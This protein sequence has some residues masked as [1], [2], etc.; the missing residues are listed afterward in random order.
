MRKT[1]CLL[2]ALPLLAPAQAPEPIFPMVSPT[3][4]QLAW[5]E[6]STWRIWIAHA[7]GSGARVFGPAWP[8]GIGQIAWTRR[9]MIVDSNYT[10]FRLSTAGKRTKLAVVGDQFFSVGATRAAVGSGQ[11]S[12]PVTV[13][14][15]LTRKVTRIGSPTVANGE[16]SLAPDGRRLAWGGP[17]GI[18]VGPSSGGPAQLLIR[19]GACPSW[20]PNGRSIAYLERGDLHVVASGGGPGRKLVARAGGC[21]TFA[22]SPDSK[23]I[24]FT[25][26]RIDTVSIATARVTKSPPLGR[27]AGGLVWGRDGS[28]LYVTTRPVADEQALNNCTN[29]WRLDARTLRGR[30]LVRGCP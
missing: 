20:S 23:T 7:D 2:L 24:A 4:A 25:P 14:D 28:E 1:L 18:W 26:Q 9:G 11:G 27:V 10:L 15:L 8:Q 13:V 22:W 21:G 29:L 30:V 5:V 17:G 6:G 16:P 19:N 3:G 12:G